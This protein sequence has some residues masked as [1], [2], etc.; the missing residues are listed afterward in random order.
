MVAEEASYSKPM[1]NDEYLIYNI[2]MWRNLCM[3]RHFKKYWYVSVLLIFASSVFADGDF[4]QSQVVS[5]ESA[6]G[7]LRTIGEYPAEHDRKGQVV[8]KGHTVTLLPNDHI[9]IYGADSY[10][11]TKN[12][13]IV[14]DRKR[15]TIVVT[16]EPPAISWFPELHAWKVLGRPAECPY[17]SYLQ[18]ATLLA[19]NRILFSGGICDAPRLVNETSPYPAAFKKQSIWNDGL[20]KWESAPSLIAER[21]YHTATSLSDGNVLITG[22]VSD[23]Y[24]P[25]VAQPVKYSVEMYMDVTA[26][27]AA[28]MVPLQN[29]HFARARHTS[30]QLGDGSVMVAGGMDKDEKA[31]A[32]IEIWNPKTKTWHDGPGLVTP[33]F[34][35]MSLLLNDGRLMIAGGIGQDGNPTRSVEIWNPEKQSWTDAA[36]LLQ[37]LRTHSAVVLSSGDVLVTG[38]GFDDSNNTVSIVM[39]W[40]K[41]TEQWKFAGNLSPDGLSDIRDTENYNLLAN[42]DKSALVFGNSVI[43][44]WLPSL[45]KSSE[46]IPDS[47]RVGNAIAVL[48]DG[49]VLLA[50]GKTGS[51]A[52]DLAEIYDP[53]SNRFALTGN[54]KQP[55]WTGMPFQTSISSVVT[56]DGRVVLA[57]GWVSNQSKTG[58]AIAN[59]AEAWDPSTSEWSIIRGLHF[60]PLERVYLGKLADGRVLFLASKEFGDEGLAAYHSLTWNPRDNKVTSKVVSATARAKAAIA[61]L[62]DGR[63]LIVGGSTREFIPEHVCPK[64]SPAN[65]SSAD[66]EEGDGCQDEA[67]HWVSYENP[68]AQIWDSRTGVTSA[69]PYPPGWHAANPQT[70]V[71]KNGN[72]VLV[73]SVMP[74]PMQEGIEK[75]EWL[76]DARHNTWSKLPALATNLNWPMTE[77]IDGSIIAWAAS[78]INPTHANLLKP[79]AASWE[80]ILRFPQSQATVTQLPSGKL[81]AF[82]PAEPYVSQFEDNSKQWLLQLN[83]YLKTE[84]PALVELADGDVA[85]LGS[86]F[87]NKK[88]LQIWSPKNNTWV[89]SGAVAKGNTTGKALRLPSGAV[90][91]IGYGDAGSYVCD[92]W[93]PDDDS[94]SFCGNFKPENKRSY[95]KFVLGSLDD[96]RGVFMGS[97]ETAF[98]FNESSREWA[99][100]QVEWNL[101]QYT[102][103]IAVHGDKPI[104]QFLDHITTMDRC[105]CGWR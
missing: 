96:G 29:L 76:F 105:R 50:G 44:Q 40:Q 26:S 62:N 102:Y 9:F 24:T 63:V 55:R 91:N 18:T 34:N 11:A 74:Y 60:E 68:T 101:K 23:S 58:Q 42:K 31:I 17:T 82:S 57:G 3:W 87:G 52:S 20:Q 38:T 86:I 98:V 53:V 32:S 104:A 25:A 67:A 72:V 7:S 95:G 89:S 45:S 8:R 84:K 30:T 78:N 41:N 49:K 103:G 61:I 6:V 19:N 46:Y 1:F 94:W 47:G 56:N 90:M 81:L 93:N 65:H 21:I 69:L 35:H 13:S 15:R 85:V 75:E 4:S 14:L 5:G 92:I 77:L 36:P 79:G 64:M 66:G 88:I 39:L 100:M 73:N 54:M 43:M 51:M 22:G 2:C 59:F 16:E 37:P 12:G 33:R 10:G 48:N 99:Q 80:H 28:E 71:L 27:H 97:S 70:L 83:Y